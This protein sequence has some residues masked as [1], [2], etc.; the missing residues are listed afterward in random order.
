MATLVPKQLFAREANARLGEN[1]HTRAQLP[2][3]QLVVIVSRV[4][5]DIRLHM[6]F[7]VKLLQEQSFIESPSRRV[8]HNIH[9]PTLS[10]DTIFYHA[11]V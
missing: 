2:Q 3:S 6:E 10:H 5:L 7:L 1:A 4:A 9:I 8:L 11:R